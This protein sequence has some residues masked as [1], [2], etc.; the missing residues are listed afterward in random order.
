M[1][2]KL[3]QFWQE[4]KRRKVTRV[5]TIYA[6]AAFVIME[7]VDIVAPNLGLPAWTFNLVL[8][9]LLVGFVITVIVSWIYD[10]HPEGGIVKTEPSHKVEGAE[11]PKSSRSWKIASYIS[12]VVIVVLIVLNIIP[13]AGK[14]DILDKSIVVLPF[15]N[16]SSDQENTYFIDGIMESI[17]DNLCRIE[18]LRVPGRTS[19]MQYR[20]NPKPIPVVAEEMDVAYVLEG[21]GQKIG[22]RLLLTVQLLIGEEDR[23]IWSQSYDRVIEKMEDLFDIQKEVAQLVA[24]EIEAVITPEEIKR[25]EK[26]PTTSLTANDYYMRGRARYI[27]FLLNISDQEALGQAENYFQQALDFDSTFAQAYA[28]LAMAYYSDMISRSPL[29]DIVSEDYLDSNAFDP[30]LQLANKALQYDDQLPEAYVVRGNYHYET[31][32]RERAEKD[33]NTALRLNPNLWEANYMLGELYFDID[34]VKALEYLKIASSLNRGYESGLALFRI[35]QAAA[36]VNLADEINSQITGLIRL[37]LDSATYYTI[38]SIIAGSKGNT[39][40][41]IEDLT[42]AYEIGPAMPWILDRMAELSFQLGSLQDGISYLEKNDSVLSSWGKLSFQDRHRYGYNYFQ[43][44]FTEKARY[45][46]DMQEEIC[47]KLIKLNRP[48]AQRT[49]AHYDLACV[50]AFRGEKDKAIE[51]LNFI[52][53]RSS[54]TVVIGYFIDWDPLF[55][56]I[57]D[58]GEFQRIESEIMVKYE[59]EKEKVRQWLEE[60][61]ML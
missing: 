39:E 28:G 23:H 1:P 27:E 38:L 54:G 55:D 3:S 36:L 21:S 20:E 13:R 2:N 17:L 16:L 40:Q 47:K 26:I 15:I 29:N 61:D 14:K 52:N 8:I 32:Q 43:A 41:Q 10:I 24:S 53:Q 4:L 34:N 6:A 22:N 48:N 58:D 7:L 37:N 31:G 49:Y 19:V 42:R 59:K 5:I 44:G 45:Y 46:I 56:K 9:L 35:F 50:Y 25:I 33:Y 51:L 60:N 30:V 12:F 11:I 18:D 57:R